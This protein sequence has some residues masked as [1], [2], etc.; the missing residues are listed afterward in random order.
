MVEQVGK[1]ILNPTNYSE[2]EQ[3]KVQTTLLAGE[4]KTIVLPEGKAA[5]R[6]LALKLGSYEKS[7]RMR[8]TIIK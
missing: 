1:E 6:T 8:S 5:L 2:G 4:E 3:V 7:E